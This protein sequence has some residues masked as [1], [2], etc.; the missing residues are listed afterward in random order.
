MNDGGPVDA[1]AGNLPRSIP[2]VVVAAAHRSSDR[3]AVVDGT[4][5]VSYG[6]LAQEMFRAAAAFSAAGLQKGDRVSLWAPNGLEWIV[7]ALG[8]QIAGGCIVPLNTRFKGAEVQH[9]LHCSRARFLVM[10]ER[11]LGTDYPQLLKGFDL[12]YVQHTILLPTAESPGSWTEFLATADDRL[13]TR[14]REQLEGLSGNEVSDIMFTSGT[15]GSPKGVMT[16]H[17]QNVRVYATWSRMNTLCEQDRYLIVYPFFH[18][19][20]YK[21]GWLACFLSGATAHPLP[22]LDVGTLAATVKAERITFL[23]GPPTLFQTL[24][25]TPTAERPDLSSI[26]VA[27]TGATTVPPAIIGR[28]RSE[29]GI[30]AVMT[31]YGLTETCGTVTLTAPTDGPDVV[32]RYC[33]RAID[34]VEICC[35]DDSNRPVPP[36]ETG[37]VLVRG[38]NVML[39][40]FEDEAAT[41][42]TIDAEGWLHTG[43][44]GYLSE[45]GYLR[46]TDRKTDMF[47]V[48]GFN[49]YPAE[50][51]KIM[52]GNPAYAQVAVVGVPDERLGEV[53]LAYVVPHRDATVTP[54]GVI[55]W[56]REA[57]A[58]YKVP[59]HVRVVTELPTNS[60]GKV[61]KYTLREMAKVPG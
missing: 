45:S 50:I 54:E 23:P 27:Q 55:A 52:C 28:M 48:G 30:Q 25:S 15:T 36:G 4:R 39:G 19:S 3:I 13:C 56:C 60:L 20:G 34:G 53:G 42:R 1:A 17:A 24:L 11:F 26:R 58:N 12:P 47:I 21:A 49:C 2:H 22:A 40:Y 46:L 29:L 33:G 51:E 31:G 10:V 35:V 43:D 18:C 57:M 37:E 6:A 59:R 7:A 14:A 32:A 38:Y 8:V 16:T 5:R 44:I 61:L 41:A 9:V